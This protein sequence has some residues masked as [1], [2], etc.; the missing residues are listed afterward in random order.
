MVSQRV[1]DAL[2]LRGDDGLTKKEREALAKQYRAKTNK[3]L[4]KEE[5]DAFVAWRERRLD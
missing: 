5:E 3:P 1:L 4:T 2:G